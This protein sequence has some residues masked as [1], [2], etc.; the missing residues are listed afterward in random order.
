MLPLTISEKYELAELLD[1]LLQT[2]QFS[3]NVQ[4]INE[5]TA[6]RAEELMEDVV[7]CSRAT[8]VL[9]AA[10]RCIP[11]S[12]SIYGWLIGC[13]PAVLDIVKVNRDPLT[14][15]LLCYTPIRAKHYSNLVLS[16]Q[17]L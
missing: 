16:L 6:Q 2:S 17:R 14:I 3:T 7:F 8:T 15:S 10:I 4:N 1:I 9:F 5:I 12:R 13:L 11:K